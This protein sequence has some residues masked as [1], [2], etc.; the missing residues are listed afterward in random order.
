MCP[1]DHVAS[2]YGIHINSRH[3]D[4]TGRH[5]LGRVLDIGTVSMDGIWQVRDSLKSLLLDRE[6]AC[7]LEHQLLKGREITIRRRWAIDIADGYP[8]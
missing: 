5:S 3:V 7:K 8:G 4:S 1:L 6:Q 2:T